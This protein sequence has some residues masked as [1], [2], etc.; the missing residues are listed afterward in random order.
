M[1]EPRVPRLE[2]PFFAAERRGLAGPPYLFGRKN[3]SV[4]PIEVLDLGIT[5]QQELVWHLLEH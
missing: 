4:C 3:Y 5:I 2:L 1:A